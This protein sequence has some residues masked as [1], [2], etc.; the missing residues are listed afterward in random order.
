ME[1]SGCQAMQTARQ[2]AQD[3]FGRAQLGDVRRTRR[4]VEMMRAAASR[5]D[6]CVSRVFLR[7][8]Q[9]QAAYDLLEHDGVTPQAASR[10][11]GEAAARQCAVHC[12]VLVALDGSGLT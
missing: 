11:I 3:S 5:P 7:A 10:A 4:F 12:R 2:W 8:G 9:R 6:G 1:L